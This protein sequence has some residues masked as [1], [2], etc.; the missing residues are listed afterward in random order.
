MA[1]RIFALLLGL[2]G[3]EAVVSWFYAAGSGA[4]FLQTFSFLAFLTGLVAFAFAGAGAAPGRIALGTQVP[5][6]LGRMYPVQDPVAMDTMETRATSRP[7]REPGAAGIVLLLGL[8]AVL[9][10]VG[11]VFSVL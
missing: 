7:A 6:R 2:L 10:A 11:F 5:D 4:P 1:S 3:V 8:G 9:V